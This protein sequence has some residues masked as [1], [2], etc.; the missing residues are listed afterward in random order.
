[1][2]FEIK[3]DKF[4]LRSTNDFD[5]PAEIVYIREQ[6]PREECSDLLPNAFTGEGLEDPAGIKSIF[7]PF[8]RFEAEAT[9]WFVIVDYGLLTESERK[10]FDN[11]RF[12][13]LVN[14][15]VYMVQSFLNDPG[16]YLTMQDYLK[17]ISD[18]DK[19]DND[20]ESDDETTG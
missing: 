1:M 13:K 6:N 2:D 5:C 14:L 4:I 15:F 18:E 17:E 12:V 19:E 3:V 11:E 7:I 16:E 9:Q 8:V 20:D 10:S